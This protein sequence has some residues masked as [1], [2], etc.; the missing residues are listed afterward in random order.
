MVVEL[1]IEEEKMLARLRNKPRVA[2]VGEFR[3]AKD[4]MVKTMER[5]QLR[6][7]LRIK[8]ALRTRY[9]EL[10]QMLAE[11]WWH[12]Q[13]ALVPDR[14]ESIDQLFQLNVTESARAF[15]SY[16]VIVN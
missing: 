13:R 16:A 8:Q 4:E 5:V 11:D 7:T 3:M 12:A 15:C 2:D 9:Q 1:L 6:H 10:Y 14:P